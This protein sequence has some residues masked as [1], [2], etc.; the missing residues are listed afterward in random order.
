MATK[1]LDVHKALADDTRF[2]LYRHLRLVGRPVSVREMSG[3]LGLHPNTLRPHLR[4]LEEAGLVAHQVRKTPGVG[5][6]QTLYRSL[7]PTGDS[8]GGFRLLAEMLCGLLHT[9]RDIERATGLAREWGQY[10]VTQGGPKPGVRL[11]ARQNL[12]ALQEAMSRAGFEPR[13]RRSGTG[14]EINLRE[15]PFRDLADEYRDLV[16][17]LHR[18]L[19]EGMLGGL[20]PGMALR[21]FR[22]FAERG[23]CRARAARAR[24]EA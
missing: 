22:P 7:E 4:R 10:L 3:R 21:D 24:V 12:A 14:V 13:F 6:P 23:V 18:G 1:P 17:S 2:R 19:I 15:C 8:G 20:K 16:C 9:R 5:R 11:P